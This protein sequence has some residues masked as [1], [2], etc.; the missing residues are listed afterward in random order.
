QRSEP[1]GV[2]APGLEHRHQILERSEELLEPRG[3]EGERTAAARACGARVPS[4][5]R[6]SALT[7]F[8]PAVAALSRA[9]DPRSGV[10]AIA[11]EVGAWHQARHAETAASGHGGKRAPARKLSVTLRESF[12]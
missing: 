5:H 4:R 9:A 2:A 10:A 7:R 6:L 11:A 3:F 8:A 1:R 12:P